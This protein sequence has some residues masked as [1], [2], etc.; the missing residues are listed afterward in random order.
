[1]IFELSGGGHKP[2]QTLQ[3]S[4]IGEISDPPPAEMEATAATLTPHAA[5]STA[6]APSPRIRALGAFIKC[7]K[8]AVLPSISAGGGSLISPMSLIG[9]PFPRRP[10]ASTR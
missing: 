1:M 6:Y 5:I 4:D 2:R 3:I 7:R 9:D 10:S 8:W